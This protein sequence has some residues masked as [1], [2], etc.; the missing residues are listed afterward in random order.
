[1]ED[2]RWVQ[3]SVYDVKK[4]FQRAEAQYPEVEKLM[5]ALVTIGRRLR[6]YFVAHKIVI[7][8]NQPLKKVLGQPDVAKWLVGWA[9]ELGDHD[10]EYRPRT[11]IKGQVVTDFIAKTMMPI[12]SDGKST[13]CGRIDH[14]EKKRSGDY[15]SFPKQDTLEFCSPFGFKASKKE[16]E[17]EALLVGLH[18]SKEL[19]V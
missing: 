2:D 14:G 3:R 5:L 6:P 18:L 1:M 11:I 8:T 9:I 13:L 7:L 12:E 19:G 10:I 17:Y 16:V 4:A 15:A